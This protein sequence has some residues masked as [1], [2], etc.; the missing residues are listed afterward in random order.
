[1]LDL[2]NRKSQ[3]YRYHKMQSPR[4]YTPIFKRRS[5]RLGPE[6]LK[7][8]GLSLVLA[9]GIR[10]FVAEARYIPSGS[11]LP[12]LAIND[13]LMIEKI[14][15]RFHPPRRGDAIVF[16]PPAA[17]EAENIGPTLIKRVVGLPGE[18]VT[19][20]E[21]G[22]YI[23]GEL[24]E[25]DYLLAGEFT[26]LDL[27]YVIQPEKTPYL[28]Q[29]VTI[30]PDSYLVLGDNRSGSYDSRCWGVVP[31]DKIL[32]R[33]AVRFWPPQR[34]GGLNQEVP[35]IPSSDTFLHSQNDD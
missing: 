29:P 13:R 23:N 33:A 8:V 9:V 26:D 17:L 6:I 20:Q 12:T 24:L 14:S 18:T 16:Y 2:R 4:Y 1:L 28:S 27:C 5:P 21:G 10:S 34:A 3:S 22:V 32:G 31:A 19:L 25:E 11:M 15:Y 7:T 30:P 35:P